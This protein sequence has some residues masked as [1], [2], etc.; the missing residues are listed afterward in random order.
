MATRDEW[1]DNASEQTR[2]L[3]LP[4]EAAARKPAKA[5]RKP[6]NNEHVAQA[7]VIAWTR[8]KS[9]ERGFE[10]LD[11]LFAIPNGGQRHKAVAAKLKREGVKRGVPDM[12][13]PVARGGF[14][15][16]FIEMKA[17]KG[18][19]R[20]DQ[21]EW[22]ILLEDQGYCMCVCYGYKEATDTLEAYMLRNITR[23]RLHEGAEYEQTG[24]WHDNWWTCNCSP[25][26]KVHVPTT[27]YCPTCKTGR[28][29]ISL[30]D[31]GRN[32]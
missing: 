4:G 26:S 21:K 2:L 24:E 32:A 17:L 23:L 7:K 11:L 6:R 25:H 27:P 28:P 5:R 30:Y 1:L 8:R 18:R 31:F 9:L 22:H 15:G 29:R 16:L 19:V 13:L 10:D 12:L 14:H 20:P 3:N